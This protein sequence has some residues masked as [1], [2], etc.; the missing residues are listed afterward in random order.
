M[1]DDSIRHISL[2]SNV[3]KLD[4]MMYGN[5]SFGSSTSHGKA[6]NE[7]FMD[8]MDNGSN[9]MKCAAALERREGLSSLDEP[10]GTY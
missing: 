2:F 8:A 7:N 3:F 10:S 9:S 6:V 4:R 1:R 5:W